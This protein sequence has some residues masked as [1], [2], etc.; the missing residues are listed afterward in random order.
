MRKVLQ[1]NELVN[2][3]ERDRTA[4]PLLAKHTSI[5]P[6]F[7]FYRTKQ[8]LENPCLRTFGHKNVRFLGS[9]YTKLLH[10]P[11]NVKQGHSTEHSPGTLIYIL[12]RYTS[13]FGRTFVLT[14]TYKETHEHN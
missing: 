11:K 7:R 14:T 1:S 9:S 6:V 5:T 12:T 2:G 13:G 8:A 10:H 4:D 3:A